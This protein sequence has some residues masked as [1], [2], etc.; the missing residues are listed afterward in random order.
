MNTLLYEDNSIDKVEPS[1]LMRAAY[2]GDIN[3]VNQLLDENSNLELKDSDGQTAL[4]YACN[5][6]NVEIV[7]MLLLADA[8]Y[9]CVDKFGKTCLIYACANDNN[10]IIHFLLQKGADATIID[11]MEFTA[12]MTYI[13]CFTGEINRCILKMLIVGSKLVLG[14]KIDEETAYDMYVRNNFKILDDSDLKLLKG[15]IVM[16]E[17]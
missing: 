8:D 1:E 10:Q 12:L 11:N 6:S 4:F 16:T 15:E 5:G 2:D 13:D 3:K 17:N 14:A 7:K 9:N